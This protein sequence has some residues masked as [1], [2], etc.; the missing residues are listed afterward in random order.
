MF[1]KDAHSSV[2]RDTSYFVSLSLGINALS[3]HFGWLTASKLF[4]RKNA[5]YVLPLSMRVGKYTTISLNFFDLP[6]GGCLMITNSCK[7]GAHSSYSV[8]LNLGGST[9]ITGTVGPCGA[10][11]LGV[12]FIISW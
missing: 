1:V 12:I 10:Y 11:K 2:M 4:L 9:S 5:Y 7:N 8:S 6:L 3:Q